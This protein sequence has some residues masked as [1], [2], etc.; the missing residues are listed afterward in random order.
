M[1]N[2]FGRILT[3][4]T[5]HPLAFFGFSCWFVTPILLGLLSGL[6]DLYIPNWFGGFMF[7]LG[8]VFLLL[9]QKYEKGG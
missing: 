2:L 1:K 7:F 9:S 6:F 8:I 3:Y 4:G 5:K